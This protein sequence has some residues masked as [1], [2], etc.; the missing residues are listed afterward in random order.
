[1]LIRMLAHCASTHLR[2]CAGIY[3]DIYT[4]TYASA[5]TGI[6]A[7]M[8]ASTGM[9]TIVCAGSDATKYAS[10]HAGIYAHKL[11]YLLHGSIPVRI[12]ATVYAST[13]ASICIGI[14]ATC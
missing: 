2:A 10:M 11:P 1:M 12:Y 6:D 8:C 3:A 14:Y 9:N 5:H 13:C 7:S 4:C